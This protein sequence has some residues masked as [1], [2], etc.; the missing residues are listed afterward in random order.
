MK[1]IFH[2][3]D[4][5]LGISDTLLPMLRHPVPRELA[6]PLGWWYVFGSAS[7]TLFAL[8]IL[9]G[10]GLSLTYVPS[11]DQAY[12]SLLYLNYQQPW[13][14]FLRSLH[15]WSG[16]AM[17]VMVRGA[18]DA[19]FLAR[20]VQ[21]SPRID[22]A[23]RRLLAALHAWDGF[24]RPGAAVGS[25]RLLGRGCRRRDGGPRAGGRPDDCR[26]AVRR[27]DH[28]RRHAQSL[29]RL[30]R[31]C[32]SGPADLV[33]LAALVVGAEEGYQRA[34]AAGPDCRSGDV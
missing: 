5:R 13:G 12:E 9:T 31:V 17:V 1:R 26:F 30:A 33:S 22:M 15:Y 32:H 25:R 23:P 20:A 24:H 11:A 21:I 10:I 29:F 2:W 16:S 18:H 27:P 7:L 34:A 3:F 28:R 4:F 14:W 19:G 6:G 8:Q